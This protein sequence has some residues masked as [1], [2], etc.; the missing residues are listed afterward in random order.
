LC[1][2]QNRSNRQITLSSPVIQETD[3]CGTC[4][5]PIIQNVPGP[6]GTNGVNGANGANGTNAFTTLSSNFTQPAV[7]STVNI[8][9]LNSTWVAPSQILFVQG[10]GYYSTSSI[11]DATHITITNLGYSGNAAPAANIPSAGIVCPGGLQGPAGVIPGGALLAANNLSDVANAATS[12][13]NLGL[14]SLSVLNSVNNGNW[15]GTALAIANGGTGATLAATALSNLGGQ[16]LNSLLTSLAGQGAGTGEMY[17]TSAPNTIAV[18]TSTAFGRS[19]LTDASATAFRS[20][21]GLLLPQYG[22]LCSATGVNLNS[23]A[24]D[25]PMTVEAS[26]YTIEKMFVENAS[27]SLTTATAGVFTA[28]GGGGTTLAADQALAA[29]TASTKYLNLTAAGIVGTDTRAE[30]TL[31]FRCGTAQG[32]AATGSIWIFGW[33]FA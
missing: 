21:V 26:R 32:A 7:N 15:S 31:Y 5:S 23:G 16:P 2:K 29:L 12:R 8:S 17:Y 19:A 22:L 18:V 25:T 9:V 4:P 24:T 14:G 30:G 11:P 27:I 33:K 13:S 6:Q 3:C 20:R 1:C 28:A 10:G